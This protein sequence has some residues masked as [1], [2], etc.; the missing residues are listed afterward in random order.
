MTWIAVLAL[1]VLLALAGRALPMRRLA[2]QWMAG[3]VL[4]HLVL[5]ACDA[6]GI[7][8][9]RIVVLVPLMVLAWLGFRRRGDRGTETS[10]LPSDLG[11]GDAAALFA[12]T[13]FA[14]FAPTLWTVTPDFVYHWGLK[15]EHFFL[16]R[17]V[18][19]GWL[20]VKEWS[21]VIHPDY[22]NLLPELFAGSALL[23][24]SFEAPAQML[25]SVLVFALILLASREA[26]KATSPDAA[27]RP[28]VQMGIAITAFAL[29][30][31]GLGHRM[32][33]A[34][35]GMPALALVA[36]LP[37]LFRRP[38]REGDIEI[39][40]AAA[41]AAASKIEGL[42]LAAFLVAIQLL[43]KILV[44]RRLPRDIRGSLWLTVPTALVAIPWAIRTF[45][46]G[47]YQNFNTGGFDAS[48]APV[49]LR[50]L[51]DATVGENWH[52][53][54]A[55]LLALPLLLL[56]R[57]THTAAAVISLQLAFYLWI[58]FTA[59]VDTQYQVISSFPR[60]AMHLI[61]ATIVLI[62]SL[63]DTTEP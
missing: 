5:T 36:A 24:G 58:Y 4:F 34:A 55:V 33:G 62:A 15:G 40:I 41:F 22:P 28:A 51:I 11:W 57:R 16:S 29:A 59:A 26:L 1:A 6:L 17:G 30:G 46:H 23:A 61:P 48:R 25:W 27:A 52:G 38:D 53:L 54:P 18:D 63:A 31:F 13:A 7:P 9:G 47:L 12:L 50:G 3:A 19:Y 21:W 14:L 56:V 20:A 45:G 32:A 8:W 2:L 44:E 39:G 37:A 49:I 10:R 60:L 42:P 43:R 35:D